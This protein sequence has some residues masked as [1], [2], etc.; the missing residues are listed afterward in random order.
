MSRVRGPI[1]SQWAQLYAAQLQSSGHLPGSPASQLQSAVPTQ[2]VSTPSSSHAH[3][4]LSSSPA[5]HQVDDQG[6]SSPAAPQL[7]KNMDIRKSGP[8]QPA[9]KADSAEWKQQYSSQDL[10]QPGHENGSTASAPSSVSGAN[11]V[12]ITAH[13]ER[14][15]SANMQAAGSS[16]KHVQIEI[17][18]ARCTDTRPVPTPI[19]SPLAASSACSRGELNAWGSTTSGASLRSDRMFRSGSATAVSQNG[20]PPTGDMPGMLERADKW[21]KEHVAT[22]QAKA[23]APCP[24]SPQ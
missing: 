14:R 2:G 6:A 4:P 23:S 8:A 18:E 22:L 7:A 17:R 3:D 9:A 11:M 16:P 19:A 21:W 20:N 5:Q 10:N 12:A 1:K 13:M 24:Q 15:P